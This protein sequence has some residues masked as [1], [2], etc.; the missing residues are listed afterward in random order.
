[1]LRHQRREVVC[2]NATEHPTAQWTEQQ[3]I[4]VFPWDSAPRYLLRDR[5]KVY[6]AI[7]RCRV[8]SLDVQEVLTAPQS[9]WQ[10]PDFE[11][12]IGSIRRECLNHVIIFNELHLKRPMLRV[13]PC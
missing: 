12:L 9:P 1:V 6:G 7:F 8:H 13:S 2:F 4:E 5:D 10:N 3:M 11:R